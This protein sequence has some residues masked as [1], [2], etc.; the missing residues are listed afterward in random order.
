MKILFLFFLLNYYYWKREIYF[1]QKFIGII[2]NFFFLLEYF[3]LF[4]LKKKYIYI[5]FL[6][7]YIIKEYYIN[8]KI[9]NIRPKIKLNIN[10]YN[11]QDKKKKIFI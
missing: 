6:Y 3:V 5:F 2:F 1:L 7:K 4:T 11:Y 9:K 10:N 8:F